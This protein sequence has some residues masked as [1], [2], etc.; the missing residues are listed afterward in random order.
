MFEAAGIATVAIGSIRE[1]LYGMSPPR[2]LFCDFPLGRP[3]GVPNDPAFQHRVLA[4]AFGLLESAEPTVQDFE[5]SIEDT[6]SE[7]LVCPLPA[8]HDP[9]AHPAVDEARGLR[10]AY[11]RAVEKYGNRAGAARLLDADAVPAAIESFVRVAEGVP[12]KE[13]GIP[14]VPARVSHDI[15]GYYEMAAMEIVNHTPAAWTGY[16][17]FRDETQT[18]AVIK[19]AQKA[20]RESGVRNDALWRFLLPLDATTP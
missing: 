11:D 15:R 6:A 19:A 10:A 20:I 9:D 1:Q 12:W 7:V 13:A 3:L 17:W 18:G 5:E 2:G 16:R 14:G 4:R 8:R